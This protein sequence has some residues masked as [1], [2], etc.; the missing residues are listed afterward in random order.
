MSD[1]PLIGV[2]IASALLIAMLALSIGMSRPNWP[3]HP[4]GS[5]GFITDML[6]YFFL[7]VLPMLI[8]VAGFSIATTVNPALE[9]ETARYVLLG[10]AVMG[11][12]GMRRLPFVAAAQNRVRA[13]RNARYESMRP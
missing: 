2:L 5:R 8:C 13:A 3:F 10:I 1:S 12:L 11:L 4:R 7:P 6:I 9:N